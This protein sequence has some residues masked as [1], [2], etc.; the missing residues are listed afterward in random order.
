MTR[1]N[2]SIISEY[3][4]NI[5]EMIR[6]RSGKSDSKA[7]LDGLSLGL[8]FTAI[9]HSEIENEELFEELK[10]IVNDALTAIDDQT[11]MR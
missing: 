10:E 3:S 4:D 2:D 11:Y 8:D 7:F 6:L 9:L 1:A 5:K